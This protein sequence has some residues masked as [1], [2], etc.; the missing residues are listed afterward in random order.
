MLNIWHPFLI[1]DAG[2]ETGRTRE[3]ENNCLFLPS[4]YWK[5]CMLLNLLLAASRGMC[6]TQ[7]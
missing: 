5:S 3:G 4:K 6:M 2:D 1:G 7:A